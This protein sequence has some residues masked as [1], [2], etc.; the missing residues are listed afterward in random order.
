MSFSSDAKAELCRVAVKDQSCAAA[1]CYGALLF[2]HTF[3]PREI[4]I[5]TASADFAARLPRLFRRAFAM[6]FDEL[7]GEG[8]SGKRAF[9]IRDG[10]K[11][12]EVFRA[13]GMEPGE[14]LTLHINLGV[15]EEDC[16][17]VSFV[18][19]AFLAGGSISDPEKS[20][21]LELC[22]THLSAGRELCALLRDMGAQPHI[23]ARGAQSVI[24]LKQPDVMA[25]FL[26]AVG[27]PVASLGVMSAKV[28]R[29]MRN[30]IN[31]KVNCDSANADKTVAAAQEQ[32]DAIK[33]LDREKGLDS[34]PEKLREAALLRIAN[35]AAS[36]SDLAQLAMPPVSK[37]CISHRINKIAELSRS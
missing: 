15:L 8:A 17:R 5:V 4:R 21:H 2:C 27:A 10:A 31:R 13:F 32:L 22:T 25:D 29:D 16:C 3:S 33:R 24:Y 11:I 18:R 1:E 35:P 36:L 12:R 9:V 28:D 14:T 7:P 6:R 20:Y 19:G 23:T 30:I 37:S 34:L 26:T